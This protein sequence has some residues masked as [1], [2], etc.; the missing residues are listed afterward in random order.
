MYGSEKGKGVY[1]AL[2][3]ML[4]N[5]PMLVI[6]YRLFLLYSGKYVPICIGLHITDTFNRNRQIISFKFS[7]TWKCV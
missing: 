4:A 3:C 2:P 7:P 1:N 5:A 6:F